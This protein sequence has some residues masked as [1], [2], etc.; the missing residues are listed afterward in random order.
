MQVQ[1]PDRKM[2]FIKQLQSFVRHQ[3]LA[4][5]MVAFLAG[6]TAKVK[7]PYKPTSQIK[8]EFNDRYFFDTGT[9][10]GFRKDWNWRFFSL[11]DA[12]KVA[13][14]YGP[15][16][17]DS[18]L[19]YV[20]PIYAAKRQSFEGL[21][22]YNIVC[23]VTGNAD[24][25]NYLVKHFQYVPKLYRGTAF[26]FK[27]LPD[28]KVSLFY[29]HD[30]KGR[31]IAALASVKG[32]KN[33]DSY[34]CM[35]LGHYNDV[36]TF[37]KQFDKWDDAKDFDVLKY[38][39][40]RTRYGNDTVLQL[41]GFIP[42][43]HAIQTIGTYSDYFAL[44]I[45]KKPDSL[46]VVNGQISYQKALDVLSSEFNNSFL[47]EQNYYDLQLYL[48][49][50]ATYYTFLG[51]HKSSLASEALYKFTDF[52]FEL[53]GNTEIIDAGKLVLDAARNKGIIAFNEA[54]HDVRCRAFVFS[55]LDSLKAIGFTHLALEDLT[56]M[57]ID[58]KPA[59]LSGYYCREPIYHNLVAHAQRIGLKIVIYDRKDANAN[60]QY[61]DRDQYAARILHKQVRLQKGERLIILC[62][63]GH[64]DK[65]KNKT[66]PSSLID[67]LAALSGTEPLTVDL[68]YP[69]LYSFTTKEVPYYYALK[70]NDITGLFHQRRGSNGDIA[71]Y[72]PTGVRYFD[73]SYYL[74][75]HLLPLK[76][77]TL[78]ISTDANAE[79]ELTAYVYPSAPQHLMEIPV[80]TMPVHKNAT[81]IT[82]YVPQSGEYDVEVREAGNRVVYRGRVLL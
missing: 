69:R 48:Q 22:E 54:H 42:L 32:Y 79:G 15:V 82:I 31:L 25:D 59:F 44:N 21:P 37:L 71:V 80:F 39:D 60:K 26:D 73:Y 51:D 29:R 38:R 19:R 78:S 47:E 24:L 45:F 55:L 20:N 18:V 27:N 68:A 16:L 14:Q 72:P 63:Y 36:S 10:A 4:W 41:Q 40:T 34:L 81:S 2:A 3:S 46:M 17:L 28:R 6:C 43:T 33:S 57:P 30:Q 7:L 8:Q 70:R 62:G 12:K 9:N 13:A 66:Q 77:T 56:E 53:P 74:E 23:K 52:H 58:G 35:Y 50:K 1:P 5:M 11:A 75:H 64:I 65:T 61:L 49:T 76:K 67:H